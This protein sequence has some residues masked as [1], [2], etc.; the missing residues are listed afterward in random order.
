VLFP[1][2]FLLGA[3]HCPTVTFVVRHIAARAQTRRT[4]RSIVLMTGSRRP[5][6]NRKRPWF[7]PSKH[8][9]IN[10]VAALPLMCSLFTTDLRQLLLEGGETKWAC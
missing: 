8:E 2:D 1:I 4:L 5:H 7:H 9:R 6:S 3:H 10:A